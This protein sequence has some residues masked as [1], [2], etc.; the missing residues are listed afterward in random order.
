MCQGSVTTYEYT[1]IAAESDSFVAIEIAVQM[2]FCYIACKLATGGLGQILC[3][4]S[5]NT[6]QRADAVT[7]NFSTTVAVAKIV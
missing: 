6:L 2:I 5:S 3:K 7:A 4:P 1:Y